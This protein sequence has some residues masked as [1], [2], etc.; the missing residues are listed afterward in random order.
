MV[1]KSIE[2][3]ANRLAWAGLIPFIGTAILGAFNLWVDVLLQV[4]LIYSAVILSFLG[5]IHWGLA[6]AG[7]LERPELRMLLCMAPA[8]VAWLAV[9]ALP[10][11]IALPVLAGSYLLW[12]NYDLS[13]VTAPWYERMRRPIT[14][15]AAGS[16]FIWFTVLMTAIRTAS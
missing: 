15:V 5:G 10:E 13:Q 16:H 1:T 9:A 8:L 4:F 3:R 14:F 7:Q 2:L 6:M 11:I 12:L